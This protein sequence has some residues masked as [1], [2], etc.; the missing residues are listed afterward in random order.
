MQADYDQIKGESYQ[1]CEDVREKMRRKGC[2]EKGKDQE[3]NFPSSRV[4]AERA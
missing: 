3:N 2:V 1:A 4:T